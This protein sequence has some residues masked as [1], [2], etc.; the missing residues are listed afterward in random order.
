MIR[1]SHLKLTIWGAFL[2]GAL[3]LPLSAAA[4]DAMSREERIKLLEK[5]KFEDEQVEATATGIQRSSKNT[6]SFEMLQLPPLSVFFDAIESNATILKAQAEVDEAEADLSLQKRD[7]W[8]YLSVHGNY[9]YG[10]YNI[11]GNTSDMYTP[12]YETTMDKTQHT[13]SVGASIKFTLGDIINRKLTLK[14]Y[15]S[16]VEQ[17]QHEKEEMIEERKLRILEAYNDVTA[18]L[19]TIRAKAETAAL[20]NAQMK[21]SENN[22]IQGK[23]DVITLSLERSRRS[24]AVVSY[25]ES[26]VRLHNAILLLELLT[27]V[28]LIRE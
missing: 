26:R 23:I 10:K 28:K 5:L 22:F 24:G 8:N 12:V 1:K 21:I 14:K 13:F 9:S 15:R 4:Q 19:A 25:E 27:N 3:S 7:W 20:Y 17:E 18:Q 11:I 16:R 2:A 6:T